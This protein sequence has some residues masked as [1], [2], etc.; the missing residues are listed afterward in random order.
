MIT[1]PVTGTRITLDS[2]PSFFEGGFRPFFLMAGLYAALSILAWVPL[3]HGHYMIET[4]LPLP[5]WHGHE[6]VFG[7]GTAALA[8]FLLTAV[9]NWINSGPV[10]GARLALLT[11]VWVAGRI[12]AWT[13]GAAW[14]AALD[15]AFL[16]TLAAMIAPG[17]I[18]RSGK[19]NGVFVLLLAILWS[20]NLAVHLEALGVTMGALWGL[21][22]G[23]AVLLTAISVIG[24]RIVPAFTIGGMRMAGRPLQITPAPRLDLVAILSVAGTGVIEAAGAPVWAVAIVA[25][26][27][28]GANAIRLARW[29]SW[30]TLR[31]PL[32]WVLHLGYAWL[33]V[34]FALKALAGA[35][36]VPPTA[37]VHAMTAGAIGTMVLAVMT[38]ASLGHTGRALEAGRGTVV[39]YLLV[40]LGAVLRVAAPLLGGAAEQPLIGVSGATWAAGYLVFAA[41][42]APIL[43]MPRA[44]G[45][46]GC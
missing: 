20:A 45:P 2:A 33:V 40:T 36:L 32:V 27:A 15:L 41:C 34:G 17:I 22:L 14:F 29:Q 8:G 35:G 43:L 18:L 13:A 11:A 1:C 28:A 30:R 46:A 9:P 31:V 24:G 44:P 19:R 37:V 26:V 5:Y 23:I 38:R 42:Y 21:T 10:R 25:G 39:A 3:V 12:A 4:A 16:P 6:M 7:F